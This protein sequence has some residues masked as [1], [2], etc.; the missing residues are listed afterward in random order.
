MELAGFILG[1]VLKIFT[2]CEG[3]DAVLVV[4]VDTDIN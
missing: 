4:F 2:L 1:H 3:H